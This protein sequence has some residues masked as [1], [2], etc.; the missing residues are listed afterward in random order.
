[1]HNSRRFFDI[2]EEDYL[3]EVT[4]SLEKNASEDWKK[5]YLNDWKKSKNNIKEILTIDEPFFVLEKSLELSYSYENIW[6]RG[7]IITDVRPVFN[8]A[9]DAIKKI[10]ILHLLKLEY[11]SGSDDKAICFAMDLKDITKLKKS[12]ERAERKAHTAR[13]ELKNVK[14]IVS[15]AGEEGNE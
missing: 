12:C 4:G 14:Y 2:S 9:A 6:R 11:S 7:K 13:K 10:M 1:M 5:K 8:N 15:I 3:N